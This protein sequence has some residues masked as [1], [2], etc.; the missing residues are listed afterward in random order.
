MKYAKR[1]V[2][3]PET[4][5]RMLQPS[6]GTIKRKPKDLYTAAIDLSN[7]VGKT[8]RQRDQ[9]ETQQDRAAVKKFQ[10]YK[11]TLETL[12]PPQPPIA[13][14][15]PTGVTVND[16]V[17]AMPAQYR[18]IAKNVLT[19]LGRHGITWTNKS[20][21]ILESGERIPNSN[22]TDLLKEA[23]VTLKSKKPFASKPIGWTEFITEIAW[24][25]IPKSIFTKRS[26]AREISQL[27]EQPDIEDLPVPWEST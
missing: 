7:Q 18:A 25:A 24:S 3:I 5:Y 4:E 12:A 16:I 17:T 11:R 20:E 15:P 10:R 21:L 19:Q 26:T 6:G 9:D 14:S 2:L 13:P 22:I 23:I 1:M 27:Q 8:I